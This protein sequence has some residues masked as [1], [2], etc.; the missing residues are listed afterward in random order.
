ML[1]QQG[2]TI[3]FDS[4]VERDAFFK[5]ID[6]EENNGD[7]NTGLFDEFSQMNYAAPDESSSSSSS[8]EDKNV[9]ADATLVEQDSE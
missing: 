9:V 3:V 6:Q 8:S 5:E 7:D 1:A 4:D 2:I